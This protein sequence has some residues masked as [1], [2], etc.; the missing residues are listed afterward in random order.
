MTI[1]PTEL[2]EIISQPPYSS[3]EP[4]ETFTSVNQKNPSFSVVDKCFGGVLADLELC[5]DD[6]IKV[7]QTPVDDRWKFYCDTVCDDT[8]IP[9]PECFIKCLSKQPNIEI[10]KALTLL[11][12]RNRIS[13][14]R[15]FIENNGIQILYS[16]VKLYAENLLDYD[17]EYIYYVFECLRNISNSTIFG[18]SVFED[19]NELVLIL[20]KLLGRSPNPYFSSILGTLS[21]CL[22]TFHGTSFKPK[23]EVI[24]KVIEFMKERPNNFWENIFTVIQKQNHED[25]QIIALFTERLLFLKHDPKLRTQTIIM[26]ENNGFMD[27]LKQLKNPVFDD[28]IALFDKEIE[29]LSQISKEIDVNPFSIH[30][31]FNV[32]K[33][34]I[35]NKKLFHSMILSLLDVFTNHSSQQYQFLLYLHNLLLLFRSSLSKKENLNFLVIAASAA[36]CKDPIIIEPEYKSKEYTG[37]QL[38]EKSYFITDDYINSINIQDHAKICKNIADFSKVPI[39]QDKIQQLEEKNKKI[40]SAQHTANAVKFEQEQI[41]AQLKMLRQE[42]NHLE[43]QNIILKQKLEKMNSIHPLSNESDNNLIHKITELEN[44][45]CEKEKENQNLKNHFL[46]ESNTK[47]VLEENEKLKTEL[48][49]SQN[50]IDS[51][52]E[53]LLSLQQKSN[54]EEE[55]NESNT[56]E[57]LEENEKLKT[58]LEESQKEIETLKDHLLALLN[59]S[60][61]EEEQNESNTKEIL[62]ENEK[63][64][65]E[66]E[67]SQKEIETLKDHLL[68]LLNKSNDE[69]EQNESNIKEV[70][71][72]NEKLKA[73]HEEYQN[74]IEEFKKILFEDQQSKIVELEAQNKIQNDIIERLENQ[75]HQQT[76]TINQ[77]SKNDQSSP[78]S[79]S[80]K[81]SAFDGFKLKLFK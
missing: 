5:P 10:M 47:E 11:F 14:R 29:Y 7:L 33:D 36:F 1:S 24:Q 22:V 50:E 65:T 78:Q 9:S 20:I 18:S 63:L 77:L 4:Y 69:E 16:Q 39:L 67:E 27:S 15:R 81:K 32:M 79:N 40:I 53:Q 51:L 46:N 73:G 19:L 55:Q 59:K 35:K 68:A 25:L 64:K 60:N 17:D 54:D 52:K 8:E 42:K 75:I 44:I 30:S 76:E 31:I 71:E 61:D 72:E 48:E 80:P 66:L 3:F 62:E 45:I 12:N 38:F 13:F 43:L 49:E 70:L 41:L 23:K 56:K 57:I 21:G 2:R 6:K 58:E 28:L 34:N 26:I 74:Q 37:F